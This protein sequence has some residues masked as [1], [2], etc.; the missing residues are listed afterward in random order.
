MELADFRV[1]WR[2]VGC[3]FLGGLFLSHDGVVREKH[4]YGMK[5]YFNFS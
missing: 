2:D 4:K 3:P 5:V 1:G